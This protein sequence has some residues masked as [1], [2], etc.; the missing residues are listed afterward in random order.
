MASDLEMAIESSVR[1]ISGPLP[2]WVDV[3]RFADV[4]MVVP[5]S[6]QGVISDGA[7]MLGMVGSDGS[8]IGIGDNVQINVLCGG[9]DFS[10]EEL[11]ME[12][13]LRSIPPPVG[14]M[15]VSMW[16]GEEAGIHRV[17]TASRADARYLQRFSYAVRMSICSATAAGWHTKLAGWDGRSW[18][19]EGRVR[20]VFSTS[21]SPVGLAA[22]VHVGRA[23]WWRVVV[24]GDSGLPISFST[25]AHGVAESFKLRDVPSG[26]KRRNALLHW[27]DGHWRKRRSD[28][29]AATWVRRHMRGA[30][31]FAWGD[32]D[33]KIRP[34]REDI[35]LSGSSARFGGDE[36]VVEARS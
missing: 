30:T 10:E 35:A 26:A 4:E 20:N 33:C 8:P 23:R 24:R 22:L 28:P 17:G 1:I 7:A 36:T 18:L 29:D 3:R 32:M 12:T 11:E 34:A 25:D 6:C 9:N 13:F 5:G 16:L 31:S 19:G 2:Q 15:N 14:E 21:A 27:V